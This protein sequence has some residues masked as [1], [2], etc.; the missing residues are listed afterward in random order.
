MS[1]QLTILC[2]NNVE[3]RPDLI[4]EHGFACH[5]STENKQYLFDTGNGLGLLNNARSCD[6]NLANIDAVLLSHGH[7]DHCG[8]LMQLLKLRNGRPLSIYAHPAI[9]DEKVSLRNGTERNIGTGFSR[10]E[11]EAAGAEFILSTTV[12]KL[13]GYLIF[14][15]EVPRQKDPGTDNKLYYRTDGQLTPDPL[16]DDQSLYLQ[17]ASGLT[18][19]CGCAHAGIRNI[20]DHALILT[21]AKKLHALFGGL[22]LM[23]SNPAEE[24]LIIE[25]LKQ[26]DVE[27][28]AT[29]HCT[30]VRAVGH[31]MNSFGTK[32]TSAAVGKSFQI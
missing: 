22:H 27:Q 8:G 5:I 26:L 30:G 20:V 10:T 11:A 17:T 21:G 29:S 18:I 3:P 14:S 28:L 13:P 15:G 31:L 32:V 7:W 23:F 25:D 16:L 4:G 9:F 1:M 12:L 19:L 6:I 2:D 24:N